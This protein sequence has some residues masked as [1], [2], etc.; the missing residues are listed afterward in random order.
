MLTI[1]IELASSEV[2]NLD[3]SA[4][5]SAAQWSAMV[6]GGVLA[7]GVVLALSATSDGTK[8]TGVL[9]EYLSDAPLILRNAQLPGG[10]GIQCWAENSNSEASAQFAQ[11]FTLAP[12]ASFWLQWDTDGSGM[13]TA[14]RLLPDGR[15][16]PLSS[17]GQ[18]VVED[19][20]GFNGTA[21]YV[22]PAGGAT[23]KQDDPNQD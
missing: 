7:G 6:A 22:L 1:P 8:L 17:G 21:A 14:Q 11:N 5:F 18:Q 13:W 16:V 9:S 15:T 12:G 10:T 2:D 23:G 20:A 3:P 4:G 19:F